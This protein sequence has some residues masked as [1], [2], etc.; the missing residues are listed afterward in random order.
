MEL[1]KQQHFTCNPANQWWW[2]GTLC[3]RSLTKFV[4]RVHWAFCDSQKSSSAFPEKERNRLSRRSM[5]NRTISVFWFCDGWKNPE[6]EL[7]TIMSPTDRI[8]KVLFTWLWKLVWCCIVPHTTAKFYS[9]KYFNH[10]KI[11]HCIVI[12]IN[13]DITTSNEI[14]NCVFGHLDLFCFR[15]YQ[16]ELHP[17]ILIIPIIIIILYRPRY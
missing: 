10:D 14:L 3:F 6:A 7:T 15:Q 4:W 5:K 13:T 2:C 16:P 8:D 12:Q 17:S 1:S 11:I 9:G